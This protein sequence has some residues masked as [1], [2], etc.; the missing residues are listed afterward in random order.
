MLAC[1][2]FR[3]F[4][5]F[6][7]DASACPTPLCCEHSS[8]VVFRLVSVV[9]RRCWLLQTAVPNCSCYGGGVFESAPF[10]RAGWASRVR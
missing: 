9:L 7:R 10:V 6:E 4:V 2:L 3:L 5:E 1:V 8:L